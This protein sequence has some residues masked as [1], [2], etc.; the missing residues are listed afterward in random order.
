MRRCLLTESFAFKMRLGRI[1]RR[2]GSVGGFG[3]KEGVGCSRDPQ[4]GSNQGTEVLIAVTPVVV[5]GR[6]SLDN[7][8]V[9]RKRRIAC[10]VGESHHGR[11][12]TQGHLIFFRIAPAPTF[13]RVRPSE[14]RQEFGRIQEPWH[15]YPGQNRQGSKPAPPPPPKPQPKI[16]SR[17][18][19]IPYQTPAATVVASIPH[20][21]HHEIQPTSPPR[22]IAHK[23]HIISA[24]PRHHRSALPTNPPSGLPEGSDR[25]PNQ[26]EEASLRT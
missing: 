22:P 9:F 14:W 3:G 13:L 12:A 7:I 16:H 21:S 19:K 24:F 1:R 26:S 5:G 25:M 6:Y 23:K 15:L 11:Q 10:H 8:S 18:S 2:R 20:T 4:V 17:T